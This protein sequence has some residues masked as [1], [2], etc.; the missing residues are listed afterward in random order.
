MI[1]RDIRYFFRTLGRQPG[2]ALT[3]ILSLAVG[4]GANTVMFGVA[5]AILFD[6]IA[7][8]DPESLVLLEWSANDFPAESLS[9]S[10]SFDGANARSTS[11]SSPAYEMFARNARTLSSLVAFSGIDRLN[12]SI[13][14][15]PTIA[16]GAMVSENYYDA[17]GVRAALGR[18]L[19]RD[20]EAVISYAYWRS[21]LGG[22]PNVIGSALVLNGKPFTIAGVEPRAFRGTLDVGS[23]AQVTVPLSA[24]KTLFGVSDATNPSSWWVQLMG[25]RRG[26]DAQIASELT[27]MLQPQVHGP[28]I[29]VRAL[30]GARGLG[31]TR[32]NLRQPVLILVAAVLLVLLIACT[33]VAGLL[34]A[35]ATSRRKE[36][37]VRMSLGASRTALITQLL[38]ESVTLSLLGGAAGIALAYWIRPLVPFVLTTPGPQLDVAVPIDVRVLLFTIAICVLTGVAFGIVPA[39][40]ATNI[41]ITTTTRNRFANVLMTIQIAVSIV[42]MIG[43]GLFL[44]SLAYLESS[45]RGFDANN[46]LLFRL[47]PTLNGYEGTRL[48]QF[49]DEV[50]TRVRAVPG[51]RI[52][53][54]TRYAL[55]SGMS[56][57]GTLIIEGKPVDEK[58]REYVY[59]HTVGEQFLDAMRI[60]VV[61]GRGI[62]ASDDEGAPKV[63]LITQTLARQFFPHENPIGRHIGFSKKKAPAYEIVGIVRDARYTSMKDEMPPTVIFPYRQQLDRINS[64]SFVVRTSGDPHQLANAVRAAVRNI[65]PNVPLFDVRTQTEQIDESM[66]HERA[67]AALSTFFGIVA[68]VLSCIGLYGLMSYI[69]ARRTRETG[70]RIALGA[71]ERD[72]AWNVLRRALRLVLIGVVAGGAASLAFTKYVQS[73]VYGIR[74]N[75]AAT[76]AG[77]I[78]VMVAVTLVAS[79]FPARRASRT[80]PVTALRAE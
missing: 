13:H 4:I 71:R 46:L 51:V 23:A 27:A 43:C 26:S 40:R 66:R 30:P 24:Q 53:A 73:L 75:D 70:V 48:V 74:V 72:I 58:K 39:M 68:L 7:A 32:A 34:L 62:R 10:V 65:D 76:I 21:R 54:P 64:M 8:R 17:L 5:R 44:R 60:P 2:F 52:A 80:D 77:A 36:I 3:V 42:L 63:V 35:R 47:D 57:I 59:M 69:A 41:R 50:L 22:D 25:R 45:E 79:W 19:M 38:V 55:L 6:H 15:E 14:G 28:R 37:A 12:V 29:H 11:F 56:A 16:R 33:N 18:L 9:G 78:A 61:L 67:L 20:N 31:E 1:G 49:Y